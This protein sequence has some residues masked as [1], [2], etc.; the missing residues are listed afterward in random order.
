MY[1]I[2]VDETDDHI[3][4]LRLRCEHLAKPYLYI[5]VIAEAS[6]YGEHHG[7]NGHNGQQ[8][9]VSQCRSLGH[10]PLLGKETDGK[11]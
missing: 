8:R 11:V 10:H 7:E 6:R 4:H 2:T 5:L 9:G 1:Q 3:G